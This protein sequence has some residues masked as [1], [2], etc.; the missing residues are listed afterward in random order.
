MKKIGLIVVTVISLAI[1]I[2]GIV[3]LIISC[4]GSCGAS[5]HGGDLTWVCP[6]F[7]IRPAAS[8]I[9]IVL[10]GIGVVVSTI[11]FL[12]RRKRQGGN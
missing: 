4:D 2:F 8:I 11:L 5:N 10:G 3:S 6:E 1:M 12:V 9:M 7:Y